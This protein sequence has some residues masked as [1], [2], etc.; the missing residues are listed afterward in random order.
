VPADWSSFAIHN[1]RAGDAILNF[2]YHRAPDEITLDIDSSGK[3][4]LLFSPAVSLR[5]Q[6]MTVELNG[7]RVPFQMQSNEFDRHPAL[8]AALVRG[9]NTVRIWVRNDFGISYASSLPSLG[10][11]SHGLRVT[12]ESWSASHDALTLEVAGFS[13]SQYQLPVWGAGQIASI[14]GA[15]LEGG[16]I[17]VKFSPDA[18][19]AYAREKIT[20]HFAGAASRRH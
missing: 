3:A 13:G 15:E 10:S 8:H 16:R 6:V 4:E 19:D 20:I 2:N 14:D 17:V 5:T 18:S 1:I 12:S 7:H 9:K 11:S